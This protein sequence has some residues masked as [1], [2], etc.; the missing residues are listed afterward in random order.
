MSGYAPDWVKMDLERFPRVENEYGVKTK[1][2]S[3]F[4]S[5][6]LSV[7][8][9]AFKSFMEYIK[10]VD[11]K[12]QTVIAVQVENE[13]GIL[14]AVRDFSNG[15]NEAYREAVPDTFIEHLEKRTFLYFRDMTYKGD[16]A[17]GTWED[18]FGHYAP[19]V[20]MCAGYASYIEKLAKQGK[21]IY[22]LP[23]FTNVWLKG[24]NDEK[25]G[26][27]PCGGSVPEMIDIWKC[28]APS[29]DFISP[30]IYSFEFE[31]AAE[32][33]ARED[34]PLFIPETRRDK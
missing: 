20:F 26:I 2:L 11:E 4:Q 16:A 18:V 24:N 29:L 28:M 32:L 22:N 19:E 12:E 13:V 7:E 15:S 27:Y 14:G 9:N 23:L 1:I 34:N 8:L 31:K 6:I 21:E 25:A 30:D 5:D 3:M 33:Y 10:E 17:I